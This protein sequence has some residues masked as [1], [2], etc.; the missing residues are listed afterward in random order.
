MRE[1]LRDL[2]ERLNN[3]NKGMLFL[4]KENHYDSF[5]E[6]FG[7][8]F[9]EIVMEEVE[10]EIKRVFRSNDIVLK[11]SKDRFIVLMEDVDNVDI[12]RIKMN[13]LI[14]AIEDIYINSH[15]DQRLNLSAGII[16]FENNNKIEM[17]LTNAE[18]ALAKAEASGVN[19]YSL[20]KEDELFDLSNNKIVEDLKV[21]EE[22]QK[23]N[24]SFVKDVFDQ[25][26][27]DENIFNSTNNILKVLGEKNNIDRCF[28]MEN[29]GDGQNLCQT[30]EWTRED[31]FKNKYG[32][33]NDSIKW[34]YII[35][36][37]DKDGVFVYTN[38]EV[39]K[40]NEIV[41][42]NNKNIATMIYLIIKNGAQVT[43]I[44]GFEDYEV[45]RIWGR[46]LIMDLLYCSKL[47]T[48]Y[49]LIER[50]KEKVNELYFENSNML[51]TL[52]VAYKKQDIVLKNSFLIHWEYDCRSNTAYFRNFGEN[53]FGFEEIE[54]NFPKSIIDRGIVSEDSISILTGMHKGIKDRIKYQEKKVKL[55]TLDGRNQWH[56][57]RYSVIFDSDK[58]PYLALG[59]AE[60]I[61]ALTE[62]S[63]RF[64]T[65]LHQSEICSWR[66]NIKAD[67]VTNIG[68]SF[69]G[70]YDGKKLT[71]PAEQIRQAQLLHPDYEETIEELH[72]DLSK[73]QKRHEKIIKVRKE[74]DQEWHWH[75]IIYDVVFDRIHKEPVFAIGSLVDI[76]AKIE[77]ENYYAEAIALQQEAEEENIIAV[78]FDLSRD[79]VAGGT[80]KLPLDIC[81]DKDNSSDINTLF[82]IISSN[83]MDSEKRQ[84]FLN[85]FNR[86][87]LIENFKR[88]RTKYEFEVQYKTGEGQYTLVEFALNLLINPHTKRVIGLL[89][90]YDAKLQKIYNSI[91][92]GND[93]DGY[94]FIMFIFGE[95][96]S[97]SVLNSNEIVSEFPD[98]GFENFEET[99]WALVDK[100]SI[101]E[102]NQIKDNFKIDNI[103][104]V[105]EENR[106]YEFIMEGNNAEGK[107]S[108]KKNRFT[109]VDEE[110][111][112]IMYVRRDI[113]GLAKAMFV[114]AQGKR[115]KIEFED[116]IYVESLGKKIR[117][118]TKTNQYEIVE[119][120][121][122]IEGL[123][124][125]EKFSRC[126][127]SY[128][129]NLTEILSISRYT[130]VLS[131]EE[132][133]P[134]GRNEVASLREKVKSL[135]TG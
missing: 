65:L 30:F 16:A 62:L 120:I 32:Y 85:K 114:K 70:R 134:I 11:E 111:Q 96:N 57:I 74:I 83:I 5:N 103:I 131:N 55:I 98:S 123:L 43:S 13:Q 7:N 48:I 109:Y 82:E 27:N 119:K 69:K 72:Q 54:E 8:E 28:V 40:E 87:S 33:I 100:H 17:L 115:H 41:G 117:I 66:Y 34:E 37:A 105:L 102:G 132:D 121:S 58:N 39:G 93:G 19:K 2:E 61:D 84:E 104:K 44:I 67:E 128:I 25:L 3:N 80:S 76:N 124:S 10:K 45:K 36:S 14:E 35:N 99:M 133:V 63:D 112:T 79:F 81:F 52:E 6:T 15:T 26:Y 135:A 49:L 90:C 91:L 22:I 86:N 56:L 107:K 53:H 88:N 60:N 31:K 95:S 59:T 101:V 118:V 92:N 113:S 24:I 68:G 51:K 78:T 127:R 126:H 125:K 97:Y 50:E 129:V 75:R 116:I 77:A 73:G 23:G 12:A 20:F 130:A 38:C 64:I 46:D 108:V 106:E 110:N 42:F 1:I 94:D 122:N 21:D 29:L 71:K 47:L 89:K 18:K 4:I 9:W